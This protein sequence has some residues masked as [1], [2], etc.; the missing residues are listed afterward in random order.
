[1][2]LRWWIVGAVAV[3]AGGVLVVKHFSREKRFLRF[4]GDETGEKIEESYPEN[5]ESDFEA[6]EFLV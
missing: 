2:K 6:A 3:L 1:M 4:T 5:P